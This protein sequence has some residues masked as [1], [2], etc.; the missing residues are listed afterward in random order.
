MK[1]LEEELLRY[2]ES[3]MYPFH[4]PGHKRR[5]NALFKTD[6][7]EIDGFDNLHDP[8]SLLLREMQAAAR[9][10]GTKETSILV[11]GS[12]CGILA[13]ISAAVRKGGRILIP[14][15][16]HISVYHAAYLRDLTLSYI[17]EEPGKEEPDAV[18]L[19]SPSYEGCVSDIRSWAE[20]TKKRG[21]PLI[22]DE[23]HGAHFSRHPYFP[24]SAISLGADLVIQSTHKTLPA[25]T[26]TALLHN[27]TGRVPSERVRK[28]LK[29]YES[30]SP[31][32]VLMSS[33]TAAWHALMDNGSTYFDEYAARLKNLRS[34]LAGLSNLRLAGGAEAVLAEGEL[35]PYPCGTRLDPGKIL[36]MGSGS[37][38]GCGLG[39]LLRTK[40]H[41][42]PEM[43]TK[44]SVL[45]MTS[46]ADTEEGFRRLLSA[47]FEIDADEASG[48]GPA[49]FPASSEKI[50]VPE[51]AMRLADAYDAETIDV[52]L[53]GAEGMVSA[54]FVIVYPPDVPLIIPGEVYTAELARRIGT[55][56]GVQG[57]SPAGTVRCVNSLVNPI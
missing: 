24:E 12:T 41:I 7:T 42:E 40:Y 47:L 9:F 30:S 27:V 45:L 29:I 31:S 14:R 2:A 13:A 11:N 57:V 54:D 56:P 49:P 33:V 18:V 53:A 26:Q 51:T 21:I 25:M 55:L 28:F 37:L 3:D 46:A 15:S 34:G 6:I 4:M 35:P 5:G 44:D 36:I 17:G 52:P 43:M 50:P 38:D 16:A 23:A 10:Y 19:T 8:H 48:S 39:A 1:R 20:Y 32:Y 22:V